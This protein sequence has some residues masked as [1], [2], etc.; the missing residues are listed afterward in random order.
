MI[1]VENPSTH[2]ATA[3]ATALWAT[4]QTDTNAW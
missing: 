3:T 2:V 1:F 4:K